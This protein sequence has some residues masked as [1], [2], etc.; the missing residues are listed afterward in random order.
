MGGNYNVE[1]PLNLSSSIRWHDTLV[2]TGQFAK[3][4]KYMYFIM[5]R[6]AMV[7]TAL[8]VSVV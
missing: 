8:L 3:K 4:L 7:S 2:M 6:L 1:Q 5:R